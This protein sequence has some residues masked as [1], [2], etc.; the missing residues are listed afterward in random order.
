[1][2]YLAIGG[3]IFCAYAIW[4]L[5]CELAADWLIRRIDGKVGR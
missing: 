5:A 2:I 4:S 3:A 1:M